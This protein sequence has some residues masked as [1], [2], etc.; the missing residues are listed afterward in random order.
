MSNWR[1]ELIEDE[2]NERVEEFIRTRHSHL[3]VT[4]K[5]VDVPAWHAIIKMGKKVLPLIFRRYRD[6]ADW[7]WNIAIYQILHDSPKIKPRE[8]GNFDLIRKAYLKW[9]VEKGYLDHV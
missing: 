1:T 6:S 7:W 8:C 5:I 4:D 9:G 2:F 3:S